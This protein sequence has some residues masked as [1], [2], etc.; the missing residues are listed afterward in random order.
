MVN[1]FGDA[2]LDSIG[3]ADVEGFLDGLLASRSR[4]TATDVVPRFTCKSRDS[5]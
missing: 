3:T 1:R 2:K 4:S 5:I